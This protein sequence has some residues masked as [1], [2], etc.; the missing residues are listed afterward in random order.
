MNDKDLETTDIEES[1]RKSRNLTMAMIGVVVL[2]A[3]ALVVMAFLWLRPG[4]LPFLSQILASPTAT[5]RPTRTP[6]PN[7]TPRPDLTATQ[8][9]WVKP[10]ES[11]SL[12]SMEEA[13]T[14]FNAGA[15]YLENF[16]SVRPEIP[17]IVQP[18]DLFFYDVQLPASDE[19]PV[20][21]SYGWCAS[22]EQIVTDNFNDIQLDF[23]MNESPVPLENFV[24]IN[25]V[26]NDGSGCREYAA[27]VTNWPQGQHHLETRV[28]F[29][30]DVHDGWNLFP[31]GTHILKYIV[32]VE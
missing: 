21:W 2:G 19:F 15:V 17:E 27:L 32:T 13:N 4:Q 26:N 25:T 29:T 8:L 20:V 9:A 16:A 7:Q 5:R 6:E 18:G 3:C 11:P 1:D 22:L 14:A 10:A 28:T 31:A 30:Q 24:V 23:I 12:A